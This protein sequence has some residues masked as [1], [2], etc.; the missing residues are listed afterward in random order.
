MNIQELLKIG[1]KKLKDSQIEN[2]I[3]IAKRLMCY[4]IKKD[5]IYLIT[6][7]EE[8]ITQEQEH[9]YLEYISKIQNHMPIQYIVQNQEFMKMDFF[10]NEN[11]LI[12]RQD[13]EIV[14]EEAIKIINKNKLEKILDVCTGS[15]AIIISIAKYTKASNLVA[16]DIS[17]KALEIA[18][19]NAIS[20][21]VNNRIKFIQSNMFENVKEKYDLIISNPPYIKT[22][23]I[24][25]LD[26]EVKREP[27][28]ALDGGNDGLNFYKIIAENAKKYLNTNGYLVLEIG[29]DQKEEVI[30]LLRINKYKDIQCIKDFGNNDRVIICKI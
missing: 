20:N 29:Y 8:E 27:I 16:I 18:Q 5:K 14:V 2:P 21:N 15:G 17:T 25:E 12:P 13:T 26:E 11:V 6:N 10:V 3:N 7:M 23:V 1:I 28:T 22:A 24:Q 4:T 30:N 9:D 19:K